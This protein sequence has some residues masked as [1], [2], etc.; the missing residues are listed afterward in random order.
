MLSGGVMLIERKCS[1]CKIIK[2]RSDFFNDKS[3]SS[4][5]GY[6]CKECVEKY[7]IKRKGDKPGLIESCIELLGK[8]ISL[9]EKFENVIDIT[10]INGESSINYIPI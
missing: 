5:F 9:K 2:Q 3:R 1:I 6:S 8:E 7:R 4:G 10:K